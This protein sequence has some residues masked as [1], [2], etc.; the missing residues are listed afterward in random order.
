MAHLLHLLLTV[1]LIFAILQVDAQNVSPDLAKHFKN[2]SQD[3]YNVAPDVCKQ[4]PQF[5]TMYLCMG[6]LINGQNCS[7]IENS[8]HIETYL[9]E[10]DRE[11]DLDLIFLHDVCMFSQRF[12]EEVFDDALDFAIFTDRISVLPEE[13]QDIRNMTGP[14]IVRAMLRLISNNLDV[15]RDIWKLSWNGF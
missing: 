7:D 14:G 13:A 2:D 3:F 12:F 9:K 10:E 11:R 6:N 8:T 1:A 5:L 4:D 15:F